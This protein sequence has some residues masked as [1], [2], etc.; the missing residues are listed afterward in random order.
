MS[1]LYFMLP[2]MLTLGGVLVV[3]LVWAIRSD[4]FEDMEG[5]KHRI[6]FEERSG[7]R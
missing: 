6:F 5:E 3:L 7:T 1:L 2:F 4:Q